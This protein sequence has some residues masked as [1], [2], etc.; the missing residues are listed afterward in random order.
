MKSGAPGK[1]ASCED[2]KAVES[3]K[4]GKSGDVTSLTHPKGFP[5]RIG[6]ILPRRLLLL[7][8]QQSLASYSRRN[9]A[10][11]VDPICNEPVSTGSAGAL[12]RRGVRSTPQSQPVDAVTVSRF[13]LIAGEGARSPAQQI[14]GRY[15]RERV[16]HHD[17][18]GDA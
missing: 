18:S 5:R 4:G 10:Q 11:K 8:R 1:S 9:F 3:K 6:K 17:W 2:I 15:R 12:A 7:R 14:V 16:S 13:A